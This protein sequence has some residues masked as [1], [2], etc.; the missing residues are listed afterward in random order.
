M[1]KTIIEKTVSLINEIDK[2]VIERE[3]LVR[4]M[5]L[6]IFSKSHIFLI[7]PPGVGKTYIINI[8]IRAI[9]DAK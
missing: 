6:S 4:L 7:G 5:V 3:E 8:V 1:R 9:K 2:K